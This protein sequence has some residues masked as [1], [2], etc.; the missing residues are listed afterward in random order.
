MTKIRKFSYQLNEIYP[1][2]VEEQT[3]ESVPF[4]NSD[5][6]VEIKWIIIKEE[7]DGLTQA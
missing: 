7:T 3:Y 5:L 1:D 4:Q 6:K 2:L